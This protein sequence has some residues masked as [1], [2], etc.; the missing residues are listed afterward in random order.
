MSNGRLDRA[1]PQVDEP[2]VPD[3][4]AMAGE[5]RNPVKVPMMS[6]GLWFPAF[7]GTLSGSLLASRF[8]GLGRN[9]EL[10]P[11]PSKGKETFSPEFK[12]I[13]V[14]LYRSIK[15]LFYSR[16]ICIVSSLFKT[17]IY[18]NNSHNK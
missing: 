13:G 5:I 14:F 9:D 7:A 16:L 17:I 11:G 6:F 2:V 12:S 15:L 1:M 18:K 4:F 10:L 3:E 8:A